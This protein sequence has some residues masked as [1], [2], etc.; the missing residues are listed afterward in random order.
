MNDLR[1]FIFEDEFKLT[2]LKNKIN[3]INYTDIK[4]LDDTKIMVKNNDKTII[5][6]GS[7]LV[8]KKVLSDEVLIDGSV[9]KIEF[10]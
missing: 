2:I 1:S 4:I 7:N 8:L 10:R 6:S 3:I 5:I 9:N